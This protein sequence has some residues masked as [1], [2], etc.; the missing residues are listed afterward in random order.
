MIDRFKFYSS[1]RV[2]IYDGKLL[3]KQ[4]QGMN[5]ILS[6]WEAQGLTDLRWL[7]YMLG[8]AY[9]ETA[10]TMQ[11]IEEFGKGKGKDYGKMFKYGKGPGKRVPYTVPDLLY[12][13]RGHV[14]NTWY[15]NYDALTKEALKQ[16][17][18]WDFLH[19]PELL[20]QMEPSIW[21]MFYGMQTGL[22]TGKKLADYFNTKTEDWEGGRKIIN[23]TDKAEHIA[24]M[25]KKF[26]N[27]LK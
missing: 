19:H 11:P 2:S 21:A 3:E 1:V 26:Y 9:H 23:G 13:G 25:A 22:Y 12:Y 8:T 20:L 10:A 18:G 6:E 7:A 17:K 15:E 5:A 24:D 14:Q 16:G 27:A 4:V